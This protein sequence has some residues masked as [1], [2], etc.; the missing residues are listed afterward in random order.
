MLTT[1][2]SG[3]D[4]PEVGPQIIPPVAL[5]RT[6]RAWQVHGGCS[7]GPLVRSRLSPDAV[8]MK[9]A[10]IFDRQ[11]GEAALVGADAYWLIASPENRALAEGL[12]ETDHFDPN[13]AVF[14]G[15]GYASMEDAVLGVLGNIDEHHPE[16][17]EIEVTG[18]ELSERLRAACCDSGRA[19]FGQRNGFVVVR[20]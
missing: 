18:V 11:S 17:T 7:Y 1:A 13:S 2:V 4:R 19:A 16:W 20:S 8:A 3:S 5:P 9:V 12:R 14:E 10:L 15:G 6:W